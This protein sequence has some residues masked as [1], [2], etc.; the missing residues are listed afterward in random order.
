MEAYEFPNVE[1]GLISSIR[2][3]AGVSAGVDIPSQRPPEF[4]QV[5]RVGGPSAL[6]TDRPMVQVIVWGASWSAAHDLAAKVRRV[7][8]SVQLIEGNPVYR[9]REVGGLSRSP[10]PV[11]GA[12]RYQFT[13]EVSVR[14]FNAP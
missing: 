8:R 13:V 11:D 2:A 4:A 3:E 5:S 10:D 6:V 9:V 1:R 7:V 14:G 12:P